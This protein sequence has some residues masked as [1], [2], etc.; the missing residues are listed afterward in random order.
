MIK[1][2]RFTKYPY[3]FWSFTSPQEVDIDIEKNILKG[4]NGEYS[5]IHI[6]KWKFLSLKYFIPFLF[7][8][9]FVNSNDFAL[10]FI[11]ALQYVFA[12]ALILVVFTTENILRKILIGIFLGSSIIIGFIT[13]RYDFPGYVLKYFI[14][15]ILIT[16]LYV[17]SRF[18]A[19]CLI[20]RGRVVSNFILNEEDSLCKHF[21]K[22][23]AQKK[24]FCFKKFKT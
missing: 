13:E 6:E 8:P 22:K 5:F 7:L 24:S 1:L 3:I 12:I 2:L 15:F 10:N 16:L 17:D 18:A 19:F 21:I 20:K 11:K 4:K 23:E 14:I 9:F